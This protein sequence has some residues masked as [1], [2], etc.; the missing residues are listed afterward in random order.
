MS[1]QDI[2]EIAFDTETTGLDPEV[3]HRI[4]EIGCVEMIGHVRTGRTFHAYLN[5]E[6]EVPKEAEAVH[7]L[8]TKFLSDKPKFSDV[9][10]QF[11]EF[12]EDSHLVIHNA[13]FDMKFI[14]H[15]LFLAEHATIKMERAVDTLILA[16][17]KF[18]G[19]PNSL[20]ALCK[21]F[22]IDLSAR[23]KHGALLDSELLADVYL[24]LRGGRQ[25][26]LS[27]H[28]ENQSDPAMQTFTQTCVEIPHRSFD[29]S[30]EDT[31]RHRA[32][33]EKLKNPMWLELDSAN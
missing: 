12:I 32:F 11:L 1:S 31:A 23:T 16:R 15:E 6:R 22:N 8:S 4:V 29:V 14:N 7:G 18:P 33:I 21:R 19:Q 20:D 9:A 3:G 26:T 27:L 24:E 5:P 28:L 25:T 17:Q 30:A 10:K 2:R 13:G